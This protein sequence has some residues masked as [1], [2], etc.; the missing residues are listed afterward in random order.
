[1]LLCEMQVCKV[2]FRGKAQ[3]MLILCILSPIKSCFSVWP[4]TGFDVGEAILG[5]VPG[6]VSICGG[7]VLQQL[8]EL[9]EELNRTN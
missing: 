4:H 1:M 5:F 2:S 6:Q 8:W 9:L 7:Q 3:K